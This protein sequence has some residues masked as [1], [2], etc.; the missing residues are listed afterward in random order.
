MRL[1]VGS[2][3]RRKFSPL[4]NRTGGVLRSTSRTSPGRLL[5]SID[6]LQWRAPAH[7]RTQAIDLFF[8]Q[9][10]LEQLDVVP[11]RWARRRAG[12]HVR[13]A[14]REDPLVLRRRD[15]ER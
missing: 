6:F 3:S 4:W 9:D 12:M 2:F 1:P 10:G 15:F 14:M 5:L 7:E 11:V 13:E 8:G